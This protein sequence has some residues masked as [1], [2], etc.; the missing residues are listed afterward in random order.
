MMQIR[1]NEAIKR[2]KSASQVRGASRKS[3]FVSRQ[4]STRLARTLRVALLAGSITGFA[5]VFAWV[6][7]PVVSDV[8]NQPIDRVSVAGE[9]SF[10]PREHVEVAMQPYIT[11]RFF[12]VDLT[13]VQNELLELP[14]VANVSIRRQWPG[15]LKVSIVEQI[16]VARW[17]DEYLLNSHGDSFFEKNTKNFTHLAQLSGPD[18]YE[19]EV[20]DQYQILSRI[21]RPLNLNIKELSLNHRGS[22]SLQTDKFEIMIGTNHVI[23]KIQRFVAV[24]NAELRNSERDISRIDVRYLNGVAVA[25]GNQPVSGDV[26]QQMLPNTLGRVKL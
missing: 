6:F 13:D 9:M 11:E 18:G 3:T 1:N 14:W 20:M 4:W 22:W 16:P 23:D 24:Y 17:Q 25:W 5:G 19:L 8:V 10:L 21:M 26:A 12:T 15:I 2:S 7:V